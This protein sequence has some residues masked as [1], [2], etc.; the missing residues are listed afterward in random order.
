MPEPP[1]RVF[2][3]RH[4]L[5]QEVVALLVLDH[6]RQRA[7]RRCHVADHAQLQRR[8]AAD[9]PGVAVD[10][11]GLHL[12]V[13]QEVAEG[14]VGAEH[15][16]HV[17]AIDRG[18]AAAVSEQ[19]GHADCVGIV[20]LE[21]RLAL[22]AVADRRLEPRGELAHLV[23]G[24]L[25]AVPA[26]NSHRL[27]LVDQAGHGGQVR[28]GGRAD[29][30][31]GQRH[32][33]RDRRRVRDRHVAWQRDHH[34]A[35][36]SHRGGDRGAHQGPQL[37]RVD[38][39]PDVQRGGGEERIWVQLLQGVRVQ[40]R[41]LDVAGYR[42]DRRAFLPRVEQAVD[43][44]RHARPRGAA[45][46]DRV[47]G[48]PRFGDR[49]EHAVLLMAHVDEVHRAVAPQRVDHRVQRVAHDP[50]ATPHPR[51]RQHL[52][53]AFGHSPGHLPT[54]GPSGRQ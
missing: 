48:Q 13:G 46:R 2:G 24:L 1:P 36:L 22:E 14:E 21:P 41:R 28:G 32:P 10:L 39:P 7:Q 25:A 6:R 29:R 19:A 27:C 18:V 42:D 9:V 16:Q 17:G 47:A 8:P 11:D 44:V 31:G 34:R 37:R 12:L 4:V 40:Q 45:H 53:Q 51:R 23:L 20:V 38:Q 15:Q 43:Q 49:G 26:E 50:V 30:R 52:P 35:A 54:S 33:Q 3:L 5:A